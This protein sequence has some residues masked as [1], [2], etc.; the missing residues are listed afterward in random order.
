MCSFWLR[1][2]SV[3]TNGNPRGWVPACILSATISVRDVEVPMIAIDLKIKLY[4]EGRCRVFKW[5][6]AVIGIAIFRKGVENLTSPLT[7]VTFAGS[8]A[9]RGISST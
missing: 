2:P 8:L 9:L 4:W 3:R 7:T 5:V 6:M 1:W